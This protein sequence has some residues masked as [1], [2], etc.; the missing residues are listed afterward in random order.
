VKSLPIDGYFLRHCPPGPPGVTD[1]P[2][3]SAAPVRE[4][5]SCRLQEIRYR[6]A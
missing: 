6:W 3:A 5:A 4:A 2:A 1:R